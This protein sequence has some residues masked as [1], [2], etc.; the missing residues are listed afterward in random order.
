MPKLE[1]SPTHPVAVDHLLRAC[2]EPNCRLFVTLLSRIFLFADVREG[3]NFWRNLALRRLCEPFSV[4]CSSF[5]LSIPRNTLMKKLLSMLVSAAVIAMPLATL[6]T[7]VAAAPSV[8]AQADKKD[9]GDKAKAK[10]KKTVAKKKTT[11]K[12]AA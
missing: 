1:R 11:K 10:S 9:M 12:K 5:N 8:Q 4:Y 3:Y 2:A 7:S 6:S